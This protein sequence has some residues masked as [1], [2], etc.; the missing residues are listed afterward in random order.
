MKRRKMD[1]QST[2]E[3]RIKDICDNHGCLNAQDAL[4]E[5]STYFLGNNWYTT[6][7]QTN[8]ECN[9]YIVRAIELD[10]NGYEYHFWRKVLWYKVSMWI[11]TIII[12]LAISAGIIFLSNLFIEDNRLQSAIRCV[13]CTMIGS[14]A[15][16]RLFKKLDSTENKWMMQHGINKKRGT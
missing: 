7:G 4:D 13:S 16:H 11:L 8:E 5:L 3:E 1:K 10:Y 9:P 6:S 12:T 14:I 15:G 2:V